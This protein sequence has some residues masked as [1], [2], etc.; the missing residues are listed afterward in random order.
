MTKHISK[1]EK[2]N[3]DLERALEKTRHELRIEKDHRKDKIDN[4]ECGNKSL[5]GRVKEIKE[6][7]ERLSDKVKSSKTEHESSI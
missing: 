3:E 4:L 6:E 1:L 7:C 5:E 2:E